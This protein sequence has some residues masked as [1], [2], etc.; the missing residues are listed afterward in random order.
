[1]GARRRA[2]DLLF[3]AFCAL[4]VVLAFL[5]LALFLFSLLRDAWG[6]LDWQFLTSFP[7]RSPERAGVKAALGGTLWLALLLLP[8]SVPLGVAAA[9]YLEEYARGSRW[10]RLVYLN[11]A[12]LSG[13]PSIIYGMLGLT[14]FVRGLGLGRVIL[15]GALILSLLV[16][17]LIIL[18]SREALRAVPDELRLAGLA[19]GATRWQVIRG[20][21]LPAALP[22]ILTG[23]ILA[24]SRALGE[25]APLIMVGALTFVAFLP[26]SPLD[27]FTALPV[28]VFNWAS[29]P[30]EEFLHLAAAG[31]IVLL[32]MVGVLNAVASFLRA[33]Y[34]LGGR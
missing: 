1:V 18:S 17:P 33:R 12:N 19:L 32:G 15:S 25:T 14:L 30:Q 9:V 23:V 2:A 16:L 6:W 22:G 28:Q 8:L 7:A 10:D 31:S 27:P 26:L 20:I 29:R 21:V 11:I 24:F 4:A 5:F 3:S 13:V 34:H